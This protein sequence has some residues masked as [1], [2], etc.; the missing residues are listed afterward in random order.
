MKCTIILFFFTF[1]LTLFAQSKNYGGNYDV[2]F[3]TENANFEYKLSLKTGGTFLFH[4]YANHFKANPSAQH[5][6]GK[7]T[8][9]FNK[10]IISFSTDLQND[11]DET[12]TLNFNNTKAIIDRKSSRNKSPEKVPDIM[13]IYDSKIFWIKGMKLTKLSP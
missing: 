8:W 13:R 10:K 3:K 6:F 11:L 2:R 7:G 5:T 1:S 9:K 12:Y 4:S